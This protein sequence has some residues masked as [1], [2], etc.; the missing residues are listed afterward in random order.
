MLGELLSGRRIVVT[1][2]CG[3]IGGHLVDHLLTIAGTTIIVIDDCK[4]GNYL[5]ENGGE[6][7]KCIRHRLGPESGPILKTILGQNDIIFHLAAEKLHQSQDDLTSLENSNIF[8]TSSIL[9]AAATCTSR[10]I[11]ASSL[12]AHGRMTGPALREDDVPQPLTAYG[13]SKLEGEHLL[14][15]YHQTSGLNGAALRFFFA[16]GPRQ[17]CGTGYRSVIVKTFQRLAQGKRPTIC[18]DGRQ[19]L[20]YIYIDDIIRALILAA[21]SNLNG[22]VVNIGSGYAVTILDLVQRMQKVAG[23]DYSPEFIEPDFTAGSC[24]F[25]DTRRAKE[26][27]D[28]T[29]DTPLETGLKA[30]WSWLTKDLG[31]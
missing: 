15:T 27:L 30:T 11:M 25:A 2:G 12:Y 4:Y 6:R 7:Y 17:Y 9:K 13:K 28:F 22:D 3:F 16:Y 5:V 1:G 29:A 31:L 21:E 20:D 19:A 14:S 23:T 26:K 8:G 10:V 24:R 18:G